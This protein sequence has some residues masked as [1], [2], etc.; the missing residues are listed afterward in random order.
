[1]EEKYY[2]INQVAELLDLHHK[3]I[4]NFIGDGRLKAAKVGKQWRISEEDLRAFTETKE[5]MILREEPEAYTVSGPMTA[6][7]RLRISV[8]SV[9]DIEEISKEAFMRVS[10]TLIAIM[11]GRD[12]NRQ[13]STLHM[14]YYESDRRM[15]VMLWGSAAYIEEM[16]NTISM[17]VE[18]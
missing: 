5:E 3:T 9:V 16:L 11:N 17:L 2:N 13:K 1:M 8:S 18:S 12:P 6:S 15:K 4:R 14:K 7:E 10:N